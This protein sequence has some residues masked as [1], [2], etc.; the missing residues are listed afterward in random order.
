[1]LMKKKQADGS[2]VEADH[3][4]AGTGSEIILSELDAEAV[5]QSHTKLEAFKQSLAALRACGALTAAVHLENEIRKEMR[6][7]RVCSSQNTEIAQAMARRR[8]VELRETMRLRHMAA[9]AN[10]ITQSAVAVKKELERKNNLIRKRKADLVD[11]ESLKESKH[12]MKRF[13]L[14]HLGDGSVKGGGT[15]ARKCRFEVL[16]RLMRLGTGLSVAQKNDWV[17]FRE[18]WDEKMLLEHTTT[19]GGLFATWMQKVLDDY[20]KGTN[21]SMSVFVHMETRRCFDSIP[22]LLVPGVPAVAE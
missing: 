2:D 4:V 9:D 1:M 5:N 21:N 15:A 16:D 19:W 8:D 3:A 14:L 12:T 11:L 7:M 18:S 6:R 13:S 17:W 20:E 22:A 10:K